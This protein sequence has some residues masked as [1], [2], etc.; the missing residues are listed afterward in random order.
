VELEV[1]KT[2][3]LYIGGEFV[4]SESGRSEPVY[5]THPTARTGKRPALAVRH[6]PLA[7]VSRASRKDLRDAVKKARAA[8]TGW[9]EKSGYLKGQIL[10]RMAEMLEGHAERM[11]RVLRE[12]GGATA[13]QARREVRAAIDRLVHYAGWSDKYGALLS[14][15]NPV[16]ASYFDFSVPEPM[17]VV[18]VVA[19]ETPELLGLVS[20]LAPVM[21]AGNA[22]VALVSERRP[23]AA[24]ELAEVVATADVPSGV[25]NL[26]S[27]RR[28][29][30][31]PHLARHMDV[32][33]IADAGGDAVA[34]RALAADASVNVKRVKAYRIADY[35]RDDAQ[36]LEFI[37]GFVEIKSTWHPIG[38]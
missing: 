21:V 31:L 5:A 3:K 15:V 17:G 34:S 4:R 7:N 32:D 29:E 25:V 6:P 27:G 14:T 1:R 38:V 22:A 16:A 37:E 35:F 18:G 13:T 8:Q 23:L 36:G 19:P 10:Y 12:A 2:Y 26:L 24:L 28:E 30:L 11:E 33:A 9:A 20:H